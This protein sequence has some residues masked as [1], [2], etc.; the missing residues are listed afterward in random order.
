MD[1]MD[2]NGYNGYNGYNGWNTM[3]IMEKVVSSG[4]AGFFRGCISV[5]L[6]HGM[7]LLDPDWIAEHM[8]PVHR[9]IFGL[10]NKLLP[11]AVRDRPVRLG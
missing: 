11:S 7:A 10:Y 8:K 2:T 5:V 3:H 1:T 6:G 9:S 4:V